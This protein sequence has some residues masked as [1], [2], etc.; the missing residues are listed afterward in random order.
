MN[1]LIFFQNSESLV[2]NSFLRF[3]RL[4]FFE[5][6]LM[7][8]LLNEFD[9]LALYLLISVMFEEN[10]A[11]IYFRLTVYLVY[12]ILIYNIKF[13]FIILNIKKKAII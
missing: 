9:L 3:K 13:D 12:I 6:P 1:K 10:I 5:I 4:S 8:E 11:I 7:Y 2:G